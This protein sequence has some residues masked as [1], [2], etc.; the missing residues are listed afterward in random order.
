MEDLQTAEINQDPAMEWSLSS[1]RGMSV[2]ANGDGQG[3]SGP[4][5]NCIRLIKEATYEER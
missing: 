5:Y 1:W 4:N 2:G 3:H